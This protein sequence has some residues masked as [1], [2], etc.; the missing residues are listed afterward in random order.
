M[1]DFPWFSVDTFFQKVAS[2]VYPPF[3]P[4]VL[5]LP[6]ATGVYV[7]QLGGDYRERGRGC[8]KKKKKKRA[9]LRRGHSSHSCP[10]PY[11]TSFRTPISASRCSRSF[12]PCRPRHPPAAPQPR[13]WGRR[14]SSAGAAFSCAS[15]CCSWAAGRSWA[16]GWSS[17][18][19]RASGRASPSGTPAARA[20]WAS[21]WRRAAPGA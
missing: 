21:S 7:F 5:W 16:A 19:L 20:R 13:A 9:R 10:S 3:G 14:F 2:K 11:P 17:R 8:W 4:E 6:C 12:W 18:V 15:R 1:R